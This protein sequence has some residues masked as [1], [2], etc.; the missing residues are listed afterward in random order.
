M[1]L[2]WCISL[3]IFVAEE[4]VGGHVKKSIS[5]SFFNRITFYFAVR[6]KMF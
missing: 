6:Y 5:S 1:L 4:S 2:H 3:N